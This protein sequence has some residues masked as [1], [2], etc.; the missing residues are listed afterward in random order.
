MWWL[1]ALIIYSSVWLVH[2]MGVEMGMEM[3]MGLERRLVR[4]SIGIK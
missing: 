1:E 3:E 2:F 4:I